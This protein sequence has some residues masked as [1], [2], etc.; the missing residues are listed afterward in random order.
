MFDASK[1]DGEIRK[2]IERVTNGLKA[3]GADLRNVD[4]WGRRQMAYEIEHKNEAYYILIELRASA[5]A[6]IEADRS[7]LLADDIIRH[8]IIRIPEHIFGK[9]PAVRPSD[10]SRADIAPEP[11]ERKP[12]APRRTP[13]RAGA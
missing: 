3:N 8:K 2:S 10:D 1:N 12:R 4:L 5:E 6:V 11:R 9:A 13:S 7:M